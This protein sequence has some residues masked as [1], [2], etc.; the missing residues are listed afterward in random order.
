MPSITREQAARLNSQAPN[1][2]NFDVFY[3]V[4]HGEKTITRKITLD[5]GKILE[6]R[7]MYSENREERPLPYRPGRTYSVPAGHYHI[8]LHISIWSPSPGTECYHSYGL[9]QW[10]DMDHGRHTKRN[11]KDLCKIAVDLSDA[12]ILTYAGVKE[13]YD[14]ME[15]LQLPS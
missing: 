3:Y 12:D 6:A 8:A 2:W 10:L 11:Y 7:L 14:A 13:S 1:N 4:T 5:E 9:G 15:L